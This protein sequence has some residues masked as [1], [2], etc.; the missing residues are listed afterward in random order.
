MVSRA[1]RLRGPSAIIGIAAAAAFGLYLRLKDPLSSPVISAEDP[2]TH[3][4][5]AREHLADGSIDPLFEGS[6]VY[7]PGFHVL[8]ATL[9]TWT[10]LDF[11]SIALWLPALLG[12]IGVVGVA[13]LAKRHWGWEAA[14]MAAVAFAVVPEAAF[15][16]SM[17]SPTALDLALLPVLVFA[18][19]EVMKGRR[20]W[21]LPAVAL[22]TMVLVSHPWLFGVL[23][24]S[25]A[26]MIVLLLLRGQDPASRIHWGGVA[27]VV[28]VVGVGLGLAMG[29]CDDRC[30]PGFDRIIDVPG[31]P[32][33]EVLSV[34][35]VGAALVPATA[36]ETWHHRR[37]SRA[38]MGSH[39]RAAAASAHGPAPDGKDRSRDK[40]GSWRAGRFAAWRPWFVGAAS[41]VGAL[42]VLWVALSQGLPAHVSG[43]NFGRPVLLMGL[44]GLLLAPLARG[45]LAV[46]AL[47][48]FWG[49]FPFVV[50]NPFDSP[51]WPHRTMVYLAFALVLLI[52]GATHVVVDRLG[53]IG[54]RSGAR[55]GADGRARAG[56]VLAGGILLVGGAGLSVVAQTPEP[57]PWYRLYDTCQHDALQEIARET[58]ED[59]DALVVAGS[60]QAKLVLAAYGSHASRIWF[61]AGFFEPGPNRENIVRN[62]LLGGQQVHVVV[63]K[64]MASEAPDADLSF[65][66]Y[67]H[68]EEAGRWCGEAP[69]IHYQV[70]EEPRFEVKS[71]GQPWWVEVDVLTPLPVSQVEWQ[72]DG[73][74]QP[75]E[76]QEWGSWATSPS[77]P[78]EGQVRFRA[79][80]DGQWQQIG[81]VD[82][83]GQDG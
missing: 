29:G 10:G 46:L 32:S 57:Y 78:V 33:F 21:G 65:L 55:L 4:A 22:A 14:F 70:T 74:W 48:L 75:L 40:S 54:A 73:G 16:S 5:L 27:W 51:F 30:G 15:R 60:W 36:W 82:W 28:A 2:Y 49:T 83:S 34:V 20:A 76:R 41:L 52:G 19:L 68:W 35:V 63:E 79:E 3:I 11:H 44:A 71:A 72:H 13:A 37:A 7:P 24:T 39:D 38:A 64:H 45:P 26:A 62:H 1:A 42:A 6:I 9:H 23:A 77:A 31:L 80:V 69:V 18:L 12:T 61:S 58:A 43:R 47:G 25:G 67:G 59:P 8:L 56:A 81:P 66:D 17:L 50:F 53:G